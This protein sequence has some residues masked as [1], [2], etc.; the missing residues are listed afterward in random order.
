M[1]GRKNG[2]KSKFQYRQ[3]ESIIESNYRSAFEISPSGILIEILCRLA[4][5]WSELNSK[6]RFTASWSV[7][8]IT[9][10][11][12]ADSI[13][14][15]SSV[16]KLLNS[17]PNLKNSIRYGDIGTGGGVP[18]IPLCLILALTCPELNVEAYLVDRR[19]KAIAVV[20]E[21][22]CRLESDFPQIFERLTVKPVL[23][24]IS[25]LDM[26]FTI[27]T[28]RAVAPLRE[29]LPKIEPILKDNGLFMWQYSTDYVDDL[30]EALNDIPNF[31]PLHS[32]K[33]EYTLFPSLRRRMILPLRK[34]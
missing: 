29:L 14:L 20:E 5:I 2:L 15:A 18:G 16:H 31:F 30:R 17:Y 25:T 32:F 27:L 26:E 23:S 9:E 19:S 12:I 28:A 6:I 34:V 8:D 3:V 4:Y 21:T 13:F 10:D 33:L 22:L 1:R 24:D 7:E 11:L